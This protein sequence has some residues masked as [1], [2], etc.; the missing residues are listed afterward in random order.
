MRSI[1]LFMAAFAAPSFAAAPQTTQLQYGLFDTV[2]LTQPAGTPK[3]SVLLFSDRGGVDPATS[4]YAQG[5]AQAGSFV[6]TINLDAYLKE[7][8]SLT[9]A[10]SFPAG[11]VEE[12]AHW[13]ERHVNLPAYQPPYVVG[14]GAG[15]DFAYAMSVQAPSG[16]F[17][18]VATLGY[19][20]DFRLPR[21]F[22]SGD[23]GVTT[24]P[25]GKLFRIA[26]V[27]K[28][29]LPWLAQPFA[30]GARVNGVPGAL[31]QTFG[32]ERDA[33]TGDGAALAT[34]LDQLSAPQATVVATDDTLSDLPLTEIAPQGASDHR[35]AIMLTGDGGWAG[36]DKGVAAVLSQHGVRVIGLSSLEFFWHK[37]DAAQITDAVSRIV[38]HYAT[39]Y[40]QARFVLIGYSFGASLVPVVANRLPEAQRAKLSGGVMISPDDAAV[41]EIHIGDWFGNT[42]HS[43]AMPLAPEV[44]HTKI[45]LVCVYGSGESDEWCPAAAKLGPVRLVQLPGGHHYDGDYD[46]LGAA[47]LG[48]L[49][50]D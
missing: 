32:L 47:I 28:T 46:K 19:D 11:H 21:A 42:A 7:L 50:N 4:T 13:M 35:I 41:F 1:P 27:K 17:A 49:P 3:R 43:D 37:K 15:A 5:L 44:A 30:P 48:A 26:P 8:E 24:T 29:P 9:D 18:G 45:P 23:A 10:C 34:A 6:V 2:T 36:L 40:P 16:T 22:C 39:R 14:V 25:D 20:F 31:A 38:T 12:M 33:T